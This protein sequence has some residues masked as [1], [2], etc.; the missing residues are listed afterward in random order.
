MKKTILFISLTLGIGF[1][2][3][4]DRLNLNPQQS[5][6]AAT[7]LSS[8]QD[9]QSALIGAYGVNAGLLGGGLA[10]AELYGTNLNLLPELLASENYV[11]WRGTFQGYREITTKQMLATNSESQRT[12]ITAYQ[13]INI[14]N[15]VLESLDKVQNADQKKAFEGEARFLR[16]IMYFE[17]V[18]LFALPYGATAANNQLGV[19]IVLRATQTQAQAAE[20][21]AR[22]TVAEVYN[23]VLDDLQKA[24]TMLPEDNG[25]RADKYS[26]LGF[27]ARVYLQQ[28][29]YAKALAA[30]NQ[31]IESGKFRLNENVTNSFRSKNTA[32]SIFEIQQNTQNNPGTSNDG[33]TTFYASIPANGSAVG[34]GDVQVLNSFVEQYAPNDARRTELF[35]I[36]VKGN[37]TRYYTGKWSDFGTNIPV[38]RLAEM[39]LIRAEANLRLGSAVGAT[40]AADLNAVRLRAGVAPIS[41]PTVEDV[42]RERVLE[43]AFEG[44]RIHDI[45]RTR[46]SVGTL[47]WNDPKLV[48]PIP[49]REIDANNLLVQNPGY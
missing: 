35:Y 4:D 23:Q 8:A 9:I 34:R 12:W 6:D 27:L 39:L 28:A 15:S 29:D 7:A 13:V 21:Q 30:A 25:L 48:M 20:T 5:I 1:S 19:P 33:L 31:V 49:K 38:I 47:A 14:A 26:A 18:R 43:L 45:K 16:G 41:S 44:L 2:A 46:Q 22:N 3:C 36:G 24:S 10:D 40:P 11:A 42:L 32:E 17:L 37:G